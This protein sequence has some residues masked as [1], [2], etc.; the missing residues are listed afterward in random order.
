MFVGYALKENQ[1][2]RQHI[3]HSLS[4]HHLTIRRHHPTPQTPPLTVKTVSATVAS[5]LLPPQ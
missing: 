5:L 3:R 1:S 4:S 2:P